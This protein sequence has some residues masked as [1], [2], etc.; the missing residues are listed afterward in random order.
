MK[1]KKQQPLTFNNKCNCIVDYDLLERAMLWYIGESKTLMSNRVIY[2]HGKYPA[3]SIYD[4]KVHVHRLIAMYL[5]RSKIDFSIHAHHKDGNKL[6]SSEENIELIDASDH[7]SMHNKGKKLSNEHRIKIS[8]AGK[9]RS[10][11]KMVR[12]Y[13]IPISELREKLNNK[14]SIRKI[15][16]HY[17]CDWSVI[18]QRVAESL[19]LLTK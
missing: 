3:V 19:E 15:A 5:K 16:A 2:L 13:N 1:P 6:N 9:R 14:W 11:I 17:G 7:L 12:K 10:G 8:E 18:K 4:E